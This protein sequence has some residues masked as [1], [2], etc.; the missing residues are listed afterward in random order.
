MAKIIHAADLHLED[1]EEKSYCYGVLD[2]LIALALSE[3]AGALVL[4]GDLFDSFAD[5]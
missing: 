5:F 1:G 2:E 3:K 4:A